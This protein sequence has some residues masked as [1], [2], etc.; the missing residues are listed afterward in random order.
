MT[1][2][3]LPL[4][5]ADA[6]PP[7]KP[8]QPPPPAPVAV[9]AALAPPPPAVSQASLTQEQLIRQQL[10]TNQKQLLEL[11]RKNVELKLERTTAQLVGG[12][13]GGWL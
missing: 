11:Q 4:Q 3:N 1:V 10:L 13:D 5:S 7:P 6:P 12:G 8:A 2:L 9:A